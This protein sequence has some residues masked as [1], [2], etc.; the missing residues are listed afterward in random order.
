MKSY[1]ARL[2]EFRCGI[3]R[4]FWIV[5]LWIVCVVCAI[6]VSVSDVAD[7]LSVNVAAVF[8]SWSVGF[9]L[10]LIGGWLLFVRPNR[11]G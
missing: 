10:G 6:V 4:L 9:V 7:P 1:G 2:R 3:R 8:I 5:V 11:K